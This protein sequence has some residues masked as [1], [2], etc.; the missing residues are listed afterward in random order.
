VQIGVPINF[1][2]TNMKLNL[3]CQKTQ[4]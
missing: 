3:F 4:Y 2:G 1:N